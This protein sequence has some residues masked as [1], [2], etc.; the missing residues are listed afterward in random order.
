MAARSTLTVTSGTTITSAWGNSVRNHVV[1]ATGSNDVATEGQLCV[2]TVADVLV[3]HDGTTVKQ[4][5]RYG[6]WDAWTGTC[7]QAFAVSYT[8]T[9]QTH[10]LQGRHVSAS[11]LL[12]F[13]GFGS[14][15]QPISIASNLPVPSA[16]VLAGSFLYIDS[17]VGYYQG[18]VVMDT[19][20]VLTMQVHNAAASNL[21]QTPSFAIA[22]VDSLWLNLS[23][24]AAA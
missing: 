12:A 19:S 18:S 2:N 6:A 23:Y 21:G 14:V 10:T 22:N 20:G 13:T 3:V 4:L 16:P 1:P 17:G 8:S 11:G 7:T 9:N 5:A 15:G 24:P